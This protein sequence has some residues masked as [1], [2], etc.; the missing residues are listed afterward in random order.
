MENSKLFSVLK[1]HQKILDET[2]SQIHYKMEKE[3]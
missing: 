3:N 2:F 1:Q